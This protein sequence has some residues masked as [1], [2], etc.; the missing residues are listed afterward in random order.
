MKKI[1]TTLLCSLIGL[2]GFAQQRIRTHVPLDSIVLSDPCILPDSAT[3]TYYGRQTVE[4][5][6]FEILGRPVRRGADRPAVV[7]GPESH[8]MGSRTASV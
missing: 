4:K 3:M 1:L 2:T 5:Q 7:D 6:R 8:D